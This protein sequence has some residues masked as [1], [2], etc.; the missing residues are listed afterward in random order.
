MKNDLEPNREP[1]ISWHYGQNIFQKTAVILYLY[2]HK[3][4]QRN[5]SKQE[6]KLVTLGHCFAHKIKWNHTIILIVYCVQ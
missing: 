6:Q 3:A 5:T 2:I 1:K 4:I